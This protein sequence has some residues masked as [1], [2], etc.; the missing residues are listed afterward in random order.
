MTSMKLEAPTVQP[1]TDPFAPSDGFHW[2]LGPA[3]DDAAWWDAETRDDADGWDLHPTVTDEDIADEA[4]YRESEA[5]R[6]DYDAEIGRRAEEMAE[7]SA[8]MDAYERG[9]VFA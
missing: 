9:L 7:E 4:A 5:A 2:E 3:A 6:F 1:E 8:A